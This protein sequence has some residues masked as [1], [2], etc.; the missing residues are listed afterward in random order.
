VTDRNYYTL[1]PGYCSFGRSERSCKGYPQ[2]LF[3]RSPAI[4][5]VRALGLWIA[6]RRAHGSGSSARSKKGC[7][8]KAIGL[9]PPTTS[10][11]EQ[12]EN[13][14]QQ[15]KAEASAAVISDARAHVISTTSEEKQKDHENDYER[16]AAE[17]NTGWMNRVLESLIKRGSS[18]GRS[19]RGSG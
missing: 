3:E 19:P 9:E 14:N 17:F 5:P 6:L 12:E 2:R 16:H 7:Y 4:L 8:P 1:A 11:K 15:H 13:N 10:T 18:E